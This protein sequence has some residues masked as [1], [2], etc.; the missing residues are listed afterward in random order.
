MK[1]EVLP[2]NK[3]RLGN[4]NSEIRLKKASLVIMTLLV[5]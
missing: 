4:S 2:I 1:I 3:D 5:Y